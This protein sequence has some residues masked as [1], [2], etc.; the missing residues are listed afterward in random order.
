MGAGFG[1]MMK[2]LKKMSETYV[3]I[4]EEL[5]NT[6]FEGSAGGGV[7]KA[8]A[9][10]TGTV[11]SIKIDPEVLQSGDVE[12]LEDLVLTAIRQAQDKA[13]EHHTK[14]LKR[15]AGEI[16]IPGMPGLGG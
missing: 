15:V 1:K 6:I 10:G 2:Q 3:N 4:D 11:V 14:V 13:T 16:R 5:K 9:D 7:V 8:S 12:M